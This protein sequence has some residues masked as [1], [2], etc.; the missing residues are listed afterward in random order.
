MSQQ[1]TERQQEELRQ[2]IIDCL[3]GFPDRCPLEAKTLATE[4]QEG[5]VE[6]KVVYSTMPGEQV[7]AILRRPTGEEASDSAVICLHGHSLQGK[8]HAESYA[9]LLAKH[10][11]TTLAPDAIGFGER[12]IPEADD[13]RG[14]KAFWSERIFFSRGILWG[15]TLMGRM[16][17]DIMRG[18]DY[19]QSLEGIDPE[20]IGCV[21]HSM[22]GIQ[23]NFATA[24]D[25]RISV[26]VSSCGSSTY[27]AILEKDIIHALY[28]YVPGL[29][30]IADIPDIVSLIAPRPHLMISATEDATWPF[31]GAQE[32]HQRVREVYRSLGAEEKLGV[33]VFEGKHEFG[34][35]W[36]QYAC[37][38]FERYL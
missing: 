26:S 24:L 31:E 3:G 5:W 32:C 33:E 9:V 17:W 36:Q 28:F 6:S 19:L 4:W 10:G 11:F 2:K 16:V 14:A 7:P 30:K 21:G 27:H 38:W 34:P 12:T 22:G 23:T 35:D 29:L 20:R 25:Q 1:P 15:K 13:G 37:R 8:A 18:V